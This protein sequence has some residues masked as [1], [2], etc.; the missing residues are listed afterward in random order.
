MYYDI[1]LFKAEKEAGITSKDLSMASISYLVPL[2]EDKE[3][4]PESIDSKFKDLTTE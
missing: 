3:F 1:P 2:E 4:K